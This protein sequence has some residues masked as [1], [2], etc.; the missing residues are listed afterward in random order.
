MTPLDSPICSTAFA[1]TTSPPQSAPTQTTRPPVPSPDDSTRPRLTAQ[2]R[3]ITLFLG[4]L[5]VEWSTRS[6]AHS[7]TPSDTATDSDTETLIRRHHTH[8]ALEHEQRRAEAR[9]LMAPLAW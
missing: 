9:M 1:P 4:L 2:L 6:E 5:L 8:R 3:R 7:G